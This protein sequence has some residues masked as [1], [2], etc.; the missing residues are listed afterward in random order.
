V[1]SN[2]FMSA[3]RAG[4]LVGRRFRILELLGEGGFGAVYKAEEVGVG[5]VVAIKLIHRPDGI[6][7]TEIDEL[8]SRFEREAQAIGRLHSPFIVN[9][10]EL[11]MHG[12]RVFIAMEFVRGRPLA[13]LIKDEAPLKPLRAC[14]ISLQILQG[15]AE[16]HAAG[17]IHRDLKPDN[18][19][20]E[21]L[22]LGGETIKLLD[23][24][25]ARFQ[26]AAKGDMKT[27]DG[28]VLGT[29]TYMA[30]EQGLGK[31]SPQS[32][33][34][35]LGVMLFEM[36][37]GQLPFVGDT[38]LELMTRKLNRPPPIH[39][40][41]EAGLPPSL[42]GVVE[43]ALATEERDRYLNAL[44]MGEAIH[45]A[46]DESTGVPAAT[47]MESTGIFRSEDTTGAHT[48]GALEDPATVESPEADE[49]PRRAR[50]VLLAALGMVVAAS[51]TAF[52]VIW[53]RQPASLPHTALPP[54]PASDGLDVVDVTANNNG[55]DPK[56]IELTQLL[57]STRVADDSGRG[58][59]AIAGFTRF[60]AQAPADHPER[61]A[62]EKRLAELKA[63]E[64]AAPKP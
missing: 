4:T 7:Q 14:A 20:V 54:A 2:S 57:N 51:L 1:Q 9:L 35:G 21:K 17:V 36:L 46:L 34:Y 16:A 48:R 31:V 23:F 25:V 27:Q 43:R 3:M 33:I 53:L 55:L 12:Q 18:V 22:P 37:T 13:Q 28:R 58:A 44:E 11:G 40:L 49:P 8:R 32:D 26:D 39:V 6:P 30:P 10:I 5:R 47:G 42:V 29:P 15:L 56:V 59:E 62:V 50:T 52:L 24:G 19:M 64:Q 61:A 60:L 45:G 63:A 38:A 41:R